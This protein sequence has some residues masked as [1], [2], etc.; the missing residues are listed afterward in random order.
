MA[1]N[2]IFTQRRTATFATLNYEANRLN[3]WNGPGTS[4]IEP[5]LDN[6]RGNNYLFSNYYLEPGDY[7]RFRNVQV[8]YT[9]RHEGLGKLGFKLL[10]VSLGGQNVA[11][12]SKTTGY[13]PEASLANPIASGA[14]N[15]TYP[16]PATYS[17]GVN[18]TF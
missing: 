7:F 6:T 12:F 2:E 9:F 8:G 5:I 1:G 17:I 16:V 18:A 11:T 3:A 4:N 10:R 14:D 15:G 13:S